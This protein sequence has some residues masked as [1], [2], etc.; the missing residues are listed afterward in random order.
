MDAVTLGVEDAEVGRRVRQARESSG[1]SLRELARA[2]GVSPAMLSHLET[3]KARMSVVRLH[4]IAST[5]GWSVEDIL[6]P[7]PAAS[8]RSRSALDH[9]RE[10]G[11][12]GLDPVLTAALTVFLRQGYHG[13]SVRDVAAESGLS[14]SGI[15]HH[16][17]SKQEML[18]RILDLGM[19]DLL[20]RCRS[21]VA[22][23]DDEVERFRLLVD[24]MALFH[25]H[26]R[27]VGFLA[28]SEMRSLEPAARADMTAR[29]SVQQRLVDTEVEAGVAAGRFGTPYPREASRAVV[30]MCKSI[31]EWYRPDGPLDPPGVA[32]RYRRF[33]LG[34]VQYDEAGGTS[35]LS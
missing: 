24:T 6:T 4:Q 17:A 22:Q 33:A 23:G 3:G 21:A 30:T 19:N 32:E 20:A 1:R 25:T 18:Q 11:S 34:L 27:E 5:L 7:E 16:H 8:A 14:V 28:A 31:A 10:Y 15:Y 9:S 26:R 29:R 13:A 35:N 12:L 2:L